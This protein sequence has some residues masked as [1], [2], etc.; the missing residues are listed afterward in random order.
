MLLIQGLLLTAHK[1]EEEDLVKFVNL[2]LLHLKQ[3]TLLC[4]GL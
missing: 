4:R 2:D 1:Q 3:L